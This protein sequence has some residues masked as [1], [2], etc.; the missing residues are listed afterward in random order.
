[1]NRITIAL[2]ILI[3][4]A[5]VPSIARADCGVS[6]LR[7]NAPRLFAIEAMPTTVQNVIGPSGGDAGIDAPREKALLEID[8]PHTC[9]DDSDTKQ[10]AVSGT[11]RTWTNA[12][13]IQTQLGYI[14]G[15]ASGQ[16]S[17][18]FLGNPTRPCLSLMKAKL[19]I[20]FL[21]DWPMFSPVVGKALTATPYWTHVLA[22]WR[23][24]APQVGVSLPPLV[25]NDSTAFNHYNALYLAAKAHLPDGVQCAI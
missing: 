24:L 10:Q 8:A 13:N 14:R 7:A 5:L 15:V 6:Q 2:A 19:R 21:S 25:R 12:I 1:M 20:D 3:G 23:G 18:D 4:M 11:A 16:I 9:P 22:L 17:K